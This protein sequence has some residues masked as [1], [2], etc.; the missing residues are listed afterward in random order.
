MSKENRDVVQVN[1]DLVPQAPA[2]INL[3]VLTSQAEIMETLGENMETLGDGIRM[4]FDRVKIPAGGGISFEVIGEDGTPDPVKELQGVVI[5]G[6]PCNAC[7]K[8]VGTANNN[9]PDCSS[10]DGKVGAGSEALGIPAGQACATCPYN[11][12]GSDPRGG[13]GKHCKNMVRLAVLPEGYV[14]PLIVSLPPT[15]IGNWANY[16]QRLMNKGARIYYTV[17]TSIK[18]KKVQ[19]KEGTDY[20][21]VNFAKVTDLTRAEGKA[22]KDY[23][24]TLR[25]AI[26]GIAIDAIDYNVE[27]GPAEDYNPDEDDGY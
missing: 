16:L 22:I 5:D 2:T 27:P 7:W 14:F 13:R 25:P 3:P 23:A 4:Q 6:H 15:S 24:E 17:V 9:P 10:V 12:W 18:L 1:N 21:E 11:K 26:R 8:E 20:S 19:N